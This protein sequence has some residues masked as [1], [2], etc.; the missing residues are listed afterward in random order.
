MSE[1]KKLS[2]ITDL[3]KDR[4]LC[5]LADDKIPSGYILD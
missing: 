2:W 3:R 1:S 5:E 4:P